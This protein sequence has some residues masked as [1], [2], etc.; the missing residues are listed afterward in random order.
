AGSDWVVK[1]PVQTRGDYSAIE[2]LITRLAGASM[3]KIV[4]G[5]AV[6]EG[7]KPAEG[8]TTA[9]G[10]TSVP[11]GSK[12]SSLAAYGLDKP[13][14]RI[15]LGAGS[16]RATLAIGKEEDGAVYAQDEGRGMVFTIDPTVAA[17]LKKP[18]DE[19]R[20]KD[21]FEFR[22]FNLSRL[23]ISRGTDT[24]EFQKVAAT[25]ENAGDT[26]QRVVGGAASDV[27]AAKMDDLLTKLTGLR[28]QS[29][30]PA[31]NTTGLDKPALTVSASYDGGKFER[32]RLAKAAEAFA[33]REGE[34]GAAKLDATAFDE[35]VKALDAVLAPP[36]PPASPAPPTPPP[37]PR[38]P[39]P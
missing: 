8:G 21:L 17:D 13:V 22:N 7:G 16:A 39:T 6:A 28:A 38:P 26:W 31:G 11:P 34:P 32:V 1:Q 27:D 36:A 24:Y 37:A 33:A 14:A 9:E 30:V 15:T 35:V 18:A 4:E 12:I 3:T 19:Y 20:D 25:G 2:A 5:G 23:R 10:G 29:F